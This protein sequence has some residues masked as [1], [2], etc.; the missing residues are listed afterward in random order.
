MQRAADEQ[1]LQHHVV[2]AVLG[3]LLLGVGAAVRDRLEHRAHVGARAL[4]RLSF[5]P[6]GIGIERQAR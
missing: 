1:R 3:E 2:P 4:R 5:E 6:L